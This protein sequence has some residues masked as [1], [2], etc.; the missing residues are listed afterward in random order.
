MR[1][2]P[3]S[4]FGKNG[5][6]VLKA[7]GAYDDVVSGANEAP[8]YEARLRD[9]S[10]LSSEAFGLPGRG[11]MLTMTRKH[12]YD[13]ILRVAHAAGV[14]IQTSSEASGAEAEGTLVL[15][16]G[17]RFTADLVVGADGVR[18]NVRDSPACSSSEPGQ[19]PRRCDPA[20]RAARARGSGAS[21]LG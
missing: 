21:D 8:L 9:N 13:V 18:S 11:R 2:A 4:T 20:D 19:A 10:V 1:L 5:L 15:T 7:L 17:R 14:D 16:G 6:R 3:A 12:L